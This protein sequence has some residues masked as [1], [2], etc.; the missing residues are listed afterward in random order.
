MR[1]TNERIRFV[2]ICYKLL[3]APAREGKDQR[4]D[5]QRTLLYLVYGERRNHKIKIHDL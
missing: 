5:P 3:T 2:L 1:K 4:K